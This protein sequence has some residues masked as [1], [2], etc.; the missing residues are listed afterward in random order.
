[1]RSH[2]SLV[3]VY[4]WRLLETVCKRGGF[5]MVSQSLKKTD[6]VKSKLIGSLTDVQAGGLMDVIRTRLV[7]KGCYQSV[8]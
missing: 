2:H 8:L 1:M 4:H 6:P 5:L 7:Y 3:D